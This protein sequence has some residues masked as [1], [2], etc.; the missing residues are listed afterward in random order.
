M[1]G[2]VDR[3]FENITKAEN[4]LE[5]HRQM[6]SDILL[7]R[8]ML[9]TMHNPDHVVGLYGDDGEM[10]CNHPDCMIDF[11]RDSI[12]S[13]HTK[14]QMVALGKLRNWNKDSI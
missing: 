12:S 10:Q 11:K 13:I 5:L 1:R 6:K 7:L 9:W 2:E 8:S 3:L 4:A 14:F